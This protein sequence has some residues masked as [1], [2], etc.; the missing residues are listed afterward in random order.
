LT[1]GG[2]T[3]NSSYYFKF[4][5]QGT[6]RM[7]YISLAGGAEFGGKMALLDGRALN[8]A[9]GMDIVVSIIPAAAAPDNNHQ[10]AGATGLDWF[11]RLGVASVEA[12]P[13]ID[14]ATA[15]HPEVATA[16]RRS[17]LIYLLGG[18]PA[19]LATSLRGSRSWDA[20]QSALSG[21]AVLCGS[22]AG[23]MV[24]CEYFFDPRSEAIVPGLHLISGACILPHHNRFG[25][26]WKPRL[27]EL[28]PG[29]TLIGIDE[30]T[31]MIGAEDSD[32]WQVH[33]RGTVVI[34]RQNQEMTFGNGDRFALAE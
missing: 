29:S 30:Q 25:K 2:L 17:H 26:S 27:S 9:G 12:L 3:L 21:G 32:S 24:L 8:L 19:H 7:G 13:L 18:F 33:G 11:R 15:D 1:T 31:G 28:L 23:A 10:R 4:F 16:L 34:Y 14:R 5:Q 22:S 6:G 20:I